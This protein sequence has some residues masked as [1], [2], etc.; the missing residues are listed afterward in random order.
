MPRVSEVIGSGETKT[1]VLT[2]TGLQVDVRI[3]EP[4]Q[5]GAACQYFTGSKTH[6]IK[7]RQIALER[8]WL[9]T[10]DKSRDFG[11]SGFAHS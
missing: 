5:F 10:I 4:H 8:G 9:K 2:A 11:A 1:S 6:N 7:L 3:V